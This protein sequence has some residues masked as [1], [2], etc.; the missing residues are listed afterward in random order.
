MFHFLGT[1]GVV[2]KVGVVEVEMGFEEAQ[3]GKATRHPREFLQ[4]IPGHSTFQDIAAT[5]GQPFPQRR[6]AADAVVPDPGRNIGPAGFIVQINIQRIL[7]QRSHHLPTPLRLNQLAGGASAKDIPDPGAC[8]PEP[9]SP[10][11]RACRERLLSGKF[12]RFKTKPFVRAPTTMAQ[13]LSEPFIT[14]EMAARVIHCTP[15][16][17]ADRRRLGRVDASTYAQQVDAGSV[18]YHTETWLEVNRPKH[19]PVELP[20]LPRTTKKSV[21]SVELPELPKGKLSRKRKE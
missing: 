11:A 2:A 13:L 9:Y 3:G 8:R 15:K 16:A 5:I 14:E 19:K 20:N 1:F 4:L 12:I 21:I 18:L 10:E 7:P 17:L 6:I